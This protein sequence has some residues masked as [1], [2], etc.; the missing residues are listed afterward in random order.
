MVDSDVN[1]AKM[2]LEWINKYKYR[3]TVMIA[4]PYYEPAEEHCS[5]YRTQASY[6]DGFVSEAEDPSYPGTH[7]LVQYDIPNNPEHQL[8]PHKGKVLLKPV[9]NLKD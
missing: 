5:L 7:I 8:V 3:N 1:D 2:G 9:R 4:K 6:R